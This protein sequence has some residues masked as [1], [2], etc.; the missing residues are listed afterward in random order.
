MV[1][2]KL[3]ARAQ[4]LID[5]AITYAKTH[6]WDNDYEGAFHKAGFSNYVLG[7]GAFRRVLIFRH[8]PVVVK[9]VSASWQLEHAKQEMAGFDLLKKE[10]KV[11]RYCPEIYHFNPHNGVMV[12][13]KYKRIPYIDRYHQTTAR[14]ANKIFEVLN[15]D[16]GADC[17]D[18]HPNNV[19]MEGRYYKIIDGGLL[20]V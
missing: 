2:K 4:K 18:I 20:T 9:F 5:F 13:K 6:K 10:P 1:T 8:L 16:Y 12:M 3:T 17:L 14:I 11:K 19:G 7:E 15:P